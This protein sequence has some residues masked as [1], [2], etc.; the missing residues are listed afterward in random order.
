M[1][2]PSALPNLPYNRQETYAVPEQTQQIH[3]VPEQRQQ[4]SDLP[5][6]PFLRASQEQ[7]SGN[8]ANATVPQA[9]V[10]AVDCKKIAVADNGVLA[11]LPYVRNQQTIQTGASSAVLLK[12][13]VP[14]V[15]ACAA[16]DPFHLGSHATALTTPLVTTMQTTLPITSPV[17]LSALSDAVPLGA[18]PLV[19]SVL[20]NLP[21]HLRNDAAT[22]A[23][24][25][26]AVAAVLQ[27][28]IQGAR[29]VLTEEDLRA[30]FGLGQGSEIHLTTHERLSFEAQKMV[31][32]R[33]IRVLYVDDSGTVN[34]SKTDGSL[35]RVSAL[36]TDTT[37]KSGRACSQ[38]G[39]AVS[40][41]PENLTHLNGEILVPKTHPRI[42][43]R[44]KLD[45]LTASIVLVQTEFDAK[46][47][48][49]KELS[50]WLGDLRSWV[51]A[52]LRAEVTEEPLPP[53]GMG[54]MDYE[55]IHTLS[56]QPLKH[57][58]HDHI[59]PEA[60]HGFNVA[61]LNRLRA[62]VREVE[63]AVASMP[64]SRADMV[65]ALN[66]MSSAVYVLMLYTCLAEKQ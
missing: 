6:L 46:Q 12:E 9:S 22:Q 40:K 50:M 37:T 23:H 49:P 19:A 26:S 32:A 13:S 3:A 15:A 18:E 16:V 8:E 43:L 30:R 10:S 52:M 60:K 64:E 65:Q 28:K 14:S 33:G 66:R 39:T 55:K 44:G 35:Q 7:H 34:V 51:G 24:V 38:C 5:S 62:E 48:L 59:V 11:R 17:T 29:R 56:H 42:V 21:A 2:D 20:E 58:G 41:K 25:N 4:S 57:L 54:N 36:R 45:T 27:E 31:D 63:L 47:R 61:L 1:S 53:L